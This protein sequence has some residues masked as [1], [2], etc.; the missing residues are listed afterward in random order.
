MWLLWIFWPVVCLV[1]DCLP[2]NIFILAYA[3]LLPTFRHVFS[4]SSTIHISWTVPYFPLRTL[5]L[6]GQDPGPLRSIQLPSGEKN[7][8]INNLGKF[9][10]H[11]LVD[12]NQ[13]CS[14]K[15]WCEALLCTNVDKNWCSI[16][17]LKCSSD[18]PSISLSLNAK[19]D[20]IPSWLPQVFLRIVCMLSAPIVWSCS[21]DS[22]LVWD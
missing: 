3:V 21:S 11:K 1:F 8:T 12:D 4:G 16:F 17:K 2:V 15:V 19:Y 9:Q 13:V 18:C 20:G 6:Y 5:L 7:Y 22:Q 10:K 14:C